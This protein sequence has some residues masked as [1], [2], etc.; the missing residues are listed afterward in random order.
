MGVAC[1]SEAV[2]VSRHETAMLI[3]DC[4]VTLR[5]VTVVVEEGSLTN[6]ALEADHGTLSIDTCD[7]SGGLYGVGPQ[8]MPL[9]EAH[10][11]RK[12]GQPSLP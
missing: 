4:A 12:T 9:L 6:H 11:I 10:H 7:I 1:G 5:G 8:H 2:I 3:E